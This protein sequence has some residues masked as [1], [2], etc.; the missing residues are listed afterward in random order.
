MNSLELVALTKAISDKSSTYK[1][2]RNELAPGTHEVDFTARIQGSI[3]VGEDEEY[4][5]T[6]SIS[7]I[8]A[9]CLAV[10]RM[11]IQR[12]PFLDTMKEVCTEAMQAD[13]ETRKAL[14]E[15]LGVKEFEAEFK[16]RLTTQLPKATRKGKIKTAL[17]VGE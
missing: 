14:M 12:G 5:P 13:E 15:E 9:M 4:T 1:E 3:I 16:S 17:T 2:A 6:T 7:L 11:G 10:R 8:G